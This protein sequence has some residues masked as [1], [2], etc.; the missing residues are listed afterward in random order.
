MK[1]TITMNKT[2]IVKITTAVNALTRSFKSLTKVLDVSEIMNLIGSKESLKTDLKDINKAFT[3]GRSGGFGTEHFGAEIRYKGDEVTITFMISDELI[4][5]FMAIGTKMCKKSMFY[6]AAFVMN[7]A[8]ELK[9]LV[10]IIC[11]SMRTAI[12]QDAEMMSVKYNTD[13]IEKSAWGCFVPKKIEEEEEKTDSKS[14]LDDLLNDRVEKR[15]IIKKRDVKKVTSENIDT[16][17]PA[18]LYKALRAEIENE[19]NIPE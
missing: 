17:S 13:D 9:S 14:H 18:E 2:E 3:E 4:V 19:E 16:L 12:E 8:E 10:E 11:T 6:L 5:D 15:D 7:N 1:T